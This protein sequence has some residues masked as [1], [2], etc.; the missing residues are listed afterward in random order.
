MIGHRAKA[1]GLAPQRLH[2]RVHVR[3]QLPNLAHEPL[4]R[5]RGPRSEDP[6]EISRH[7]RGAAGQERERRTDDPES[8]EDAADPRQVDAASDHARLLSRDLVPLA[9]RIEQH[10]PRDVSR[11]V[12]RVRAGEERSERVADQHVRP[13]RIGVHQHAVH[14]VTHARDGPRTSRRIAPTKAGAIVGTRARERRHRVDH[15]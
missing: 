2:D 14:L 7:P 4:E 12:R 1:F 6:H 5:A 3:R 9:W 10:E 15:A 8:S 11:T 13:D